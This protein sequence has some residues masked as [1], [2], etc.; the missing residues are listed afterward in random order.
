MEQERSSMRPT[1]AKIAMVRRLSK[2]RK[3]LRLLLTRDLHTE[4]SM[5]F[6]ENRMNI[7]IRRQEM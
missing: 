4:K 2:K 1:S 3:S 6:M 5:C 7:Q